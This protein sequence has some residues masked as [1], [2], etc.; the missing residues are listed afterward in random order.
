MSTRRLA[1]FACCLLSITLAPMASALDSGAQCTATFNASWSAGTH[2]TDFPPG[3]H[4]SGLIGGTHRD[5]AV[6]WQPGGLATPGIKLMAETGGKSLLQGEVNT[7]INAGTAAAVVS[8][9]DVNPSPGMVA[10]SFGI[11]LDFPLL[12]LV[13]MIAPS[14]DWFVG[15]HGLGLFEDGQWVNQMVVDLPPYDAGTDSGITFL[16]GDAPTNPPD[17]IAQITGHPFVG[18]TLLGTFTIECASALIFADSFDD[19]T[20]SAWTNSTP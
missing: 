1:T 13:S 18:G 16:S 14:P 19:G 17:P 10:V 20:T 4:F 6:F 2:P 12:T 15:V 8:G 7:A 11:D 3:A 9:G 5:Q